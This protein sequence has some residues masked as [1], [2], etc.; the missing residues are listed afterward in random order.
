MN[1][2]GV[3][4]AIG[5]KSLVLRKN[6]PNVFFAAGVVGVVASTVMACRATLKLSETLDEIKKDV[7]NVNEIVPITEG[8]VVSLRKDKIYVYGKASLQVVRLYGP[9]ILVGGASVALLTGSHVQLTR[10]NAALTAAYA[11]LDEAFREY[12]ERVKSVV[13]EDRELDMYRG[14][15]TETVKNEMGQKEE[16]V[17]FDPNKRSVY[18]R[19]FDEFSVHWH[20]DP[21]FNRIFLQCQQNFANNLLQTRGHVFLNEVYDMLGLDRS[22]AGAVVGWVLNSDG[23]NYVDFGMLEAYN[24]KFINGFERS[25]LLDFNVDGV[26]YDKI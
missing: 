6:S 17:S 7:D 8:D 18:S 9:S 10:R 22:K 4:R 15:K 11:V 26:I 3:T 5:R 25:V 2:H 24:A 14:T 16:Q 19:I 23:D 13:G 21:E 20:K 1:F 12:R